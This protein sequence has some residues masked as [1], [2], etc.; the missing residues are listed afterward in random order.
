MGRRRGKRS[1]LL[2]RATLTKKGQITVPAAVRQ[3]LGVGPGDQIA[4]RADGGLLPLPRTSLSAL[5]GIM[6]P[7]SGRSRTIDELRQ[8]VADEL[9][10]SARIP[11]MGGSA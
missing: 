10:A 4:F 6:P 3:R 5:A 1:P 11:R 2:A 8:E 7:R 9:S